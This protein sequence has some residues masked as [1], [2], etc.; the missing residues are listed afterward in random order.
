MPLKPK[1]GR[2][3]LGTEQERL[4]ALLDH[5][6]KVFLQFGYANTSIAKI[7][8]T[9][10]V[11]TRTIYELYANKADLMVAALTHLIERDVN[12]LSEIGRLADAQPE[13]AL[14]AFGK[15]ILERV[16]SRELIEHY[17]MG[18]ADGFRFPELAKKM[19]SAG[20]KRIEGIIAEYLAIQAKLGKLQIKDAN[21]TANIFLH[22][23]TS[24][25]RQRALF[26]LL[27]QENGWDAE[28][29]IVNVIHIFLHG[30][31]THKATQ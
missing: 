16:T 4:A 17:R 3:R 6:L 8:T 20:P 28:Q 1:L 27:S 25:P 22:M 23:L 24:E 11:S 31:L 19:Q 21:K 12:Q 18:V 10:G 14:Y 29:H 5:A 26:G 9:A 2:P 15:I 13:K 7:A 30:T